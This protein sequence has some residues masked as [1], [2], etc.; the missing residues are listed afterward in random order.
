VCFRVLS[1]KAAK[2]PQENSTSPH[3]GTLP[4]LQRQIITKPRVVDAGNCCN[5]TARPVKRLDRTGQHVP[6]GHITRVVDSRIANAKTPSAIR[7][8]HFWDQE[9]GI[10]FAKTVTV[11]V[12]MTM[13]KM[14]TSL[15]LKEEEEFAKG[16]IN[17][18]SQLGYTQDELELVD[19][20]AYHDDTVYRGVDIV[21]KRK[22]QFE[23]PVLNRCMEVNTNKSEWLATQSSTVG[24]EKGLSNFYLICSVF[25]LHCQGGMQK[26]LKTF[27]VN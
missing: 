18:S 24:S 15:R 19:P 16:F 13:Q 3:G 21:R 8:H 9:A 17:D 14:T 22:R 11:T 25:E 7:Y 27:T 26:I 12:T 10:G 23:T 6:C 5:R 1:T 20:K 2:F 4:V